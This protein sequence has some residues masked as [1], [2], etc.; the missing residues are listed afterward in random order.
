MD[1][2]RLRVAFVGRLLLLLV[3]IGTIDADVAVVVGVVSRGIVGVRIL[4]ST[5]AFL[6][7]ICCQLGDEYK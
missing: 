3:V 7:F 4:Q 1:S 2:E 5:K 6:V